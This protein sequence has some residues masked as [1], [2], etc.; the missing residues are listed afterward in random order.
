MFLPKRHE[1]LSSCLQSGALE[2]GDGL[3]EPQKDGFLFDGWPRSAAPKVETARMQ[4]MFA[5]RLIV[6]DE[7]ILEHLKRGGD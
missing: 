1:S 6:P 5:K 7:L 4:R 2:L 3:M